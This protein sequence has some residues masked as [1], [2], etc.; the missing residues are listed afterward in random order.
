MVEEIAGKG[1][2][3]PQID[4]PLNILE[5]DNNN[6]RLAEEYQGSGQLKVLE[7]LYADYD[8]E[9][10]SYSMA[11]NG[12]FDE[13]PI[14]VIPENLP[15][16]F[17]WDRD[18]EELEKELEEFVE[19]NPKL[20]FIVVEGNRRIAAAKLLTYAELRIKLKVNNEIFPKPKNKA[21]EE[22]LKLIPAIVYKDREGISPYLGI[23]HISGILRW[24]AYA[25]A[26]YIAKRIEEEYKTHK[27]I[28]KC[29]TLIQMKVGDRSD[30]IKKQYMAYKLLEQAETELDID[31]KRI[32][33]R[34]S[35]INELLNKPSIRAFIG[36]HSYKE[37]D[38]NK[39]IVPQKKME[40]LEKLLI[41]VFGNGKEN[42]P[43][44]TDS[45]QIGSLLSPILADKDA[46]NCLIN[47]SSLSEAYEMS[48]GE[49]EFLMRK[50]TVAYK[51]M[52]AALTVAY[53]YKKDEEVLNLFNDLKKVFNE[54]SKMI[55]DKK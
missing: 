20:K 45:R 50:L 51:N 29:I 10:I 53:K 26:R 11:E 52:S 40:N 37:V 39:K 23:R 34:F 18:V 14:V 35:L 30:V 3:R 43:L 47:T 44:I 1:K 7:V 28:E 4:I 2:R 24:E 25:K 5:L 42:P 21:V 55:P 9:S 54:L 17:D 16:T 8:L 31:I 38:F 27:N 15:K 32:F 48:G 33:D 19:K 13:E 12:Y 6:P 49:K 36:V 22:D 41:W 46:T